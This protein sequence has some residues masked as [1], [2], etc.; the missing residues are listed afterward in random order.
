LVHYAIT[1]ISPAFFEDLQPMMIDLE[2]APPTERGA[3]TQYRA[4]SGRSQQAPRTPPAERTADPKTERRKS[5]GTIAAKS[6][7]QCPPP[8]KEKLKPVKDKP[9]NRLP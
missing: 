8:G 6:S 2:S 3:P 4:G 5:A 1:V 9:K 7:R